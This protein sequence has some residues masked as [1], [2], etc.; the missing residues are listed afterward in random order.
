[1]KED[2]LVR[3]I[4]ASGYPLQGIVARKLMDSFTV[5]EEWDYA[6]DDTGAHR[7]LDL[8]AVH[9]LAR[10]EDRPIGAVNLLVECKRSRHPF[11]FFQKATYRPVPR[12]PVVAGVPGDSVTITE[13]GSNRSKQL[14]PAEALGLDGEAFV[15]TGPPECTTM[16][17]AVARGK[18]VALSGAEPFRALV[19]P[20]VKAMRYA[21]GFYKRDSLPS[22]PIGLLAV[23]VVDAPMILVEE[24]D[25]ADDPVLVP[26]VRLVRREPNPDQ[27]SRARTR[28][29]AIDVVHADFLSDFI[30]EHVM[31]FIGTFRERVISH[32]SVLNGRGKI[33]SFSD[34]EWS[35]IQP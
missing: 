15:W 17:R 4:T 26:W 7:N 20:L 12:F 6:D 29:Y 31:P 33:D 34:F 35:R 3:A 10:H 30:A 22:F 1:M 24:P 16:S 8:L 2:E 9:N 27:S 21:Q 18:K 28:F 19:L 23:A 5:T 11:V 32:K 25:S 14:S 13:L